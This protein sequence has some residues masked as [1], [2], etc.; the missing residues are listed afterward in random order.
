MTLEQ[1]LT[2]LAAILG[3]IGSIYVLKSILRL[4]PEVTERLSAP[5]YHHNPYKIDSLSA[6]KAEGVVGTSLIVFALCIAIM[7][8]AI[9]PSNIAIFPN[10]LHAILIAIALA[11]IIYLLS[12]L[13]GKA[14]DSCH[15]RTV[16]HII[17]AQT[18]DKLVKSN[19]APDYEIKSLRYL[20]DKYLDLNPKTSETPRDLLRSIAKEVGRTLP[21]SIQIE[22]ERREQTPPNTGCT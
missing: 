21:E 2:L 3:A 6:Q 1:F 16:A 17:I 8:A 15:R 10:R 13:V 5:I 4:T 9:T 18:L 22:G 14:V 19:N 11:A 12:V 20:S 7:N